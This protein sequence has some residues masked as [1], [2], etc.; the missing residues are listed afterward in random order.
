MCPV[1]GTSHYANPWPGAN[2]IV[3]EGDSVLLGRRAHEPWLGLW[4]SPGGFCEI[5]EH[6]VDTVER[7]LLEETGLQVE[8]TRYLGTWVDAYANDP[9]ER[10]AGIINVTYYLAVPLPGDADPTDPDEVSELAWFR[11]DELPA[12]LAPPGTLEAVLAVARAAYAQ[13]GRTVELPDRSI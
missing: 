2:A 12:E 3:V 10:D 4:G 5:G 11:L 9:R 13:H 8:V 7:E 6:P 1:C